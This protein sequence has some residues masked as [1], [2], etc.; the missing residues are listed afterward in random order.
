MFYWQ[1]IF[2]VFPLPTKF[3]IIKYFSSIKEPFRK[4]IFFP[5]HESFPHANIFPSSRKFCTSKYFSFIKKVF[6]KQIFFFYQGNFR[7]INFFLHYGVLLKQ[8]FF[9]IMRVFLKPSL[10]TLRKNVL[11]YLVVKKSYK[12]N[13]YNKL[14]HLRSC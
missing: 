11:T 4:E 8:M 13:T 9:M 12:L 5:H 2:S 14:L 10:K 3:P 7:G 1:I 6:Y